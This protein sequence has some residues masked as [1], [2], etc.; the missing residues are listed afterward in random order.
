MSSLRPN[1]SASV[2]LPEFSNPIT[3]SSVFAPC[4]H[5]QL[6]QH[7]KTALWQTVEHFRLP[8]TGRKWTRRVV[9]QLQFVLVAV[10]GNNV[11][12]PRKWSLLSE[13]PLLIGDEMVRMTAGS[14]DTNSRCEVDTNSSRRL[15][16]HY[17][18]QLSRSSHHI[19]LLPQYISIV[20]V[21]A[22]NKRINGLY[23]HRRCTDGFCLV[24]LGEKG[25]RERQ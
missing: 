16:Y 25:M 4:L 12:L 3:S 9:S 7:F 11:R 13:F 23:D 14:R 1:Y 10:K 18:I 8:R 20:I 2:S 5:S 22:V 24:S 19:W 17:Q 6:N 15:W 21:A